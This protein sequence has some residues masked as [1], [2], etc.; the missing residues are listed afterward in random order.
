MPDWG[1]HNVLH[2]P[3]ED[4]KL[5]RRN[6]TTVGCCK[7]LSPAPPDLLVSRYSAAWLLEYRMELP[8]S[9]D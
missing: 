7:L 9:R 3:D 4:N 6:L 1:P 2:V 8:A 5:K